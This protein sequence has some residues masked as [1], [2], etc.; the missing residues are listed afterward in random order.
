VI[1]ALLSFGVYQYGSFGA[2]LAVL[3]GTA[4]Y[5]EPLKGPI[6]TFQ[7]LQEVS[8]SIR[9]QNVTSSPLKVLGGHST[10]GCQLDSGEF[11]F[12]LKPGEIR[13]IPIHFRSPPGEATERE[14]SYELVFYVNLVG[15]K[16]HV[17]LR[18]RVLPAAIVVDSLKKPG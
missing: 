4:L 15:E 8:E 5:I 1:A 3:E 12:E 2:L 14:F 13:Q 7:P 17:L 16:P 18:G 6:K 10:C 11:P 9:L